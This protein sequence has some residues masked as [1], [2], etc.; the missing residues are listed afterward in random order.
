MAQVAQVAQVAIPELKTRVTD[1]TQTLS[2]P[3]QAALEAKLDAFEQ[4]KR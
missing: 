3:Q 4:K 1:L 2:Q